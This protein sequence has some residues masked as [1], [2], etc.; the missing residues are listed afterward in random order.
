MRPTLDVG[1]LSVTALVSLGGEARRVRVWDSR[2]DG[3]SGMDVVGF[4]GG[5][6]HSAT[7]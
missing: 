1:W 3:S 2:F 5:I 7:V 4:G 6:A